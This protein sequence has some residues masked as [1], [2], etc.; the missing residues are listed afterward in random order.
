MST[1]QDVIDRVRVE[2]NDD[3]PGGGQ[4]YSDAKLLSFLTL[5]QREL[6]KMKPEVYAR[7]DTFTFASTSAR[8]RLSPLSYY[9]ILRVDSNLLTGGSPPY[10]V[11]TA[12]RTV[13]RDVIDSFYAAWPV[14]NSVSGI[15]SE[16]YKLAAMDTADPLAFWL[17]PQPV[18]GQAVAITSTKI[19][20]T[21]ATVGAALA[22]SD[23]YLGALTDC[24][25]HLALRSEERAE[26]E[27][28]AERYKEAF[29]GLVKA[30]RYA[31]RQ[32]TNDQARA[33]EARQ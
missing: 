19:P 1:A 27:K 24:V 2:L 3:R 18:V 8:Q 10:P 17:F 22:V 14:S 29:V 7:A 26:S 20:P 11:G 6:V 31:L 32:A 5:A 16:R 33:P 15:N 25:C 4:R 23:V 28:N 9:Q 13:E 12:I 30:S 21:V